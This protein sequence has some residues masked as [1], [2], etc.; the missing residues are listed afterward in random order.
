MKILTGRF[1]EEQMAVLRGIAPNADFVRPITDEDVLR[2]VEDAEVFFGVK[3]TPERIRRARKLRWIHN[4]GV[5]IEN[6]MFPELVNSD[7]IL[8]NGCGTTSV[9]IAEHVMAL[10]LALARALNITIRQQVKTIWKRMAD[11]SVVEVAGETLG[12]V[13][14]GHIGRQVA[15]RAN[16]FD[17]RI[18]AVDP[19]QTEKSDYVEALWKVDRLHDM[20]NQSD[21]VL[22]SC[23]LTLESEGMIGADEFRAMKSTAFFINIGRG[24]IVDTA[25]L[26]SALQNK[27][28]AGAGLDAM[29]PE[30]LPQE[31]PL[32]E[33]ENVIIS[34]HHGGQSTKAPVRQFKLYCDNLKRYV[35]GEP[36]I[37]VVD[38]IRRY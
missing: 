19:T 1:S 11:L 17:M 29:E 36:L 32:W 5:G 16:A 37:N 31:S 2:E 22:V 3:P 6:L 34:P 26:V 4:K 10:L 24:K 25:A 12:I 21:F 23:P 13:G 8:T 9:P 35:A 27:E 14:L 20:L 38:K 33:M 7:I 30:P 15:K 28:I 18:L